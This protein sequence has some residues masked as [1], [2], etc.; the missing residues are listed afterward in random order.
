M[1]PIEN[2]TGCYIGLQSLWKN[3]KKKQFAESMQRNLSYASNPFKLTLVCIKLCPDLFKSKNN[4]MPVA[5]ALELQTFID[6]QH[7][8][9]S[10]CL[11]DQMQIDVF[12]L[13]I[14][15]KNT[16]MMR[17]LT[18]V[19]RLGDVREQIVPMLR[20]MIVEEHYKEVCTFATLL[21]LQDCFST[22][23]LI[24][25]LFCLDRLCLADEFLA[26]SPK[27]QKETVIFLDRVLG[28]E[29]EATRLLEKFNVTNVGQFKSSKVLGNVLGRLL[30][31]FQLDMSICPHL[32]KRRSVGGLRYLFYKYYIE[33]GLQKPSFHSLVEDAVHETPD[34]KYT[35]IDL[36]CEYCD[37]QSAVPYIH[38]FKIDYKTLPKA[39]TDAMLACQADS[40]RSVAVAAPEE[41]WEENEDSYTLSI[42]QENIIL[43]DSVEEFDKSMIELTKSSI[44][45]LDSEWKPSFGVGSGEQV[46]LMQLATPTHAYL[47]D[48]I[49][50]QPLMNDSHWMQLGNLF[51][52][53]NITKLG[54]G[55]KN[56]FKILAKLHS[57]LKKAL[58]T[59]KN[60]ID[61][62]SKKA[63]LL[64]TLPGIFP[65]NNSTYKGLSD[66]VYRCF[67]KPLDKSEQFSNWAHRPL[68]RSQKVYA[69]LD[70]ICLIDIY[71]HLN[72]K[73]QELGL[74][75][76]Q[77]LKVT[78]PPR[79]SKAEKKG[80]KKEQSPDKSSSIQRS[81]GPI[82]AKN[83]H[84]VCDTMLQGLA[85]KLRLCGIDAVALENGQS[86]DD[87]IE[88]YEKEQRYVLSRGNSYR[89]L[90]KFIPANYLY[91]VENEGA[92]QQLEEVMTTFKV[93]LSPN[94]LF[95]RCTKCNSGSYITVPPSIIQKIITNLNDNDCLPDEWMNF[96]GE[97]IN[98]TSGCTD[99]GVIIQVKK[100]IPAVIEKAE[101][102][103]VCARC[104]KCYWDGS[105]QERAFKEIISQF[106]DTENVDQ[107][108]GVVGD[109]K[110]C[111]KLCID[112]CS[113]SG[114]D[115]STEDAYS[116]SECAQMCE[117]EEG[118]EKISLF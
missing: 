2:Y 64:E 89:R 94:D 55:I 110:S 5:L 58:T 46:S 104:G 61:F 38:K 69:G 81:Q 66:L 40:F 77:N 118:V 92:R 18:K 79:N 78:S 32:Y 30:K 70:A 35:L 105:H 51:T 21:D 37:P 68:T 56:D 4:G 97:R 96:G 116:G 24:V 7:K 31:R 53:A 91:H 17:V 101:V 87:C 83:F 62:D 71:N 74:S 76:W 63:V 113:R 28:K 115:V 95:A 1:E 65:F 25:P 111:R 3:N 47:I 14:R 41:C 108:S 50:L 106:L 33:K 82:E 20:A 16:G 22:E 27:H 73:S 15:Q 59:P 60:V 88:F 23:E 26:S 19:Y 45:G 54:Y 117:I 84:V 49:T 12:Q 102:L 72:V 6:K 114:N 98:L 100:L 43:I 99:K 80:K 107:T 103:Y 10:D 34:L 90:A 13:A 93:K 67:G 112:D 42:P 11:T 9:Y 85:K 48:I 57:Q 86:C 36:F 39:I 52:N 44:L 75:S 29:P 109:L 8:S